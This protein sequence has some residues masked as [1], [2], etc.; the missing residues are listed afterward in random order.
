VRLEIVCHSPSPPLSLALGHEGKTEIVLVRSLGAE[1]V[2]VTFA[3]AGNPFPPDRSSPNRSLAPI[4]SSRLENVSSPLA[5]ASRPLVPLSIETDMHSRS[6]D[7]SR[8]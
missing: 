3:R 8:L 1:T 7:F 4:S 2:V 6:D 5:P